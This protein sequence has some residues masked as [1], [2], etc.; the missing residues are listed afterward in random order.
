[1]K[2]DN[3]EFYFYYNPKRNFKLG[4]IF[5]LIGVL[6]AVICLPV[7][8]TMVPYLNTPIEKIPTELVPLKSISEI[9]LIILAAELPLMFGG[10]LMLILS[11]VY[12]FRYGKWD[13]FN[14]FR[15]EQIKNAKSPVERY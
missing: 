2:K 4:I 6:I 1:M 9:M 15:E 3:K 10:I 14:E 11:F 12:Y 5:I 8:I 13:L 7:L